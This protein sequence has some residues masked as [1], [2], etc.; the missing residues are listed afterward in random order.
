MPSGRAAETWRT[1]QSTGHCVMLT[2]VNDGLLSIERTDAALFGF[3]VPQIRAVGK[4]SSEG[5]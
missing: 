2:L 3:G 4:S 1:E 5:L